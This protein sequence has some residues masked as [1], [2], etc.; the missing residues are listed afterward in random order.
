MSENK[1]LHIV[2]FVYR[3]TADQVAQLNVAHAAQSVKYS[4]HENEAM[5]HLMAAELVEYLGH[6]NRDRIKRHV[7]ILTPLGVHVHAIAR[8]INQEP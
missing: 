1:P 7:Y 4:P 2:E 3:F 8:L 5:M 6:I